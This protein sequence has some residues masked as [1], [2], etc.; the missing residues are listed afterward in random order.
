MLLVTSSYTSVSPELFLAMNAIEFEGC[1][2]LSVES[3]TTAISTPNIGLTPA[4][5]QALLNG[6]CHQVPESAMPIALPAISTRL[7]IGP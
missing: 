2:V 6:T 7:F 1:L 3:P 4:F 5:L